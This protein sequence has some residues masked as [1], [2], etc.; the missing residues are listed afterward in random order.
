MSS[1]ARRRRKQQQEQ[2]RRRQQQG[3]R[4]FFEEGARDDVESPRESVACADADLALIDGML[5]EVLEVLTDLR[6]ISAGSYEDWPDVPEA[7]ELRAVFD[8][9]RTI[10]ADCRSK[11]FAARDRVE[12]FKD[13]GNHLHVIGERVVQLAVVNAEHSSSHPDDDIPF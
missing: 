5:D 1:K 7:S 13:G 6:D 4:R 12:R 10:S 2:Q 9:V 3:A 8:F 11:L